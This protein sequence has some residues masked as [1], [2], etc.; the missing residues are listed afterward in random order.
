[1]HHGIEVVIKFRPAAADVTMRNLRKLRDRGCCFGNAILRNVPDQHGIDGV[2]DATVI[3]RNRN[4]FEPALPLK[5]PCHLQYL[6]RTHAEG[7]AKNI[8]G[9]LTERKLLL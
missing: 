2:T 8:K 5:L 6:F 7:V 4:P 3:Q 1:M 9:P